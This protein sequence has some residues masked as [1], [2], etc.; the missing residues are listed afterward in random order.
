[1]AERISE[2]HD[3]ILCHILSFLPTKHAATTSILSKRWKSL[4][5]SVLTLD[6]DCKSFQDM[7]CHGYSVHQL[8]LLRK[9]ELPILLMRFNCIY[10]HDHSTRNQNNINL[11]V[12]YV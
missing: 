3:S 1:M 2:L 5:L 7:T 8:M 11:F 12:S 9:I 4:W 6:F 10:A